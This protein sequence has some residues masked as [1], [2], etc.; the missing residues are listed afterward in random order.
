[1]RP[2]LCRQKHFQ[3]GAR[4]TY[5]KLSIEIHVFTGVWGGDGTG[6]TIVSVVLGSFFL[7]DMKGKFEFQQNHWDNLLCIIF[8]VPPVCAGVFICFWLTLV[9]NGEKR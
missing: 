3:P 8:C 5:V 1:M 7:G 2:P 4:S 6:G 9:F